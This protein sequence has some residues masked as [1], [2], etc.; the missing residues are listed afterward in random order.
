[1]FSH[2]W[3][4][5][6]SVVTTRNCVILRFI[7]FEVSGLFCSNRRVF[8]LITSSRHRLIGCLLEEHLR[9]GLTSMTECLFYM[10]QCHL[11]IKSP[12]V[13]T[14]KYSKCKCVAS[15]KYKWSMY[16]KTYIPENYSTK[17]LSRFVIATGEALRTDVRMSIHQLLMCAHEVMS[18]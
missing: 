9:C 13:W 10:V 1:M 5:L 15:T 16:C 11:C 8:S 14:S 7:W 3:L 17:G 4:V 18:Y 2:G 12:I 6:I